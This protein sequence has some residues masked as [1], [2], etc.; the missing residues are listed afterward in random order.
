M[1]GFLSS[2]NPLPKCRQRPVRLRALVV[3]ATRVND[4][5]KTELYTPLSDS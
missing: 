3:Q 5:Q 2:S 4:Q 1:R